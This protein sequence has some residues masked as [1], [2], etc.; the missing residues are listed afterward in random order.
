VDAVII[1]AKST[2]EAALSRLKPEI[3]CKGAEYALPNGKPI[4]ETS[5]VTSYGGRIE[6][7]PMLAGWST[8]GIVERIQQL[9]LTD[10]R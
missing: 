4:P 3:H 10:A 6:F 1:V 7:I 2:P 8:T 5:A 9:T